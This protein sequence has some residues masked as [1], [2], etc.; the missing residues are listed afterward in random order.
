MPA[1]KG[2]ESTPDSTVDVGGAVQGIEGD[3]VAPP[4]APFDEDGLIILLRNLHSI[5][6]E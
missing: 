6:S 4:M 1:A 5:Y 2:G 3:T